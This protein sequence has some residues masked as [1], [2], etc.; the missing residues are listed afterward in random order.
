MK[1]RL[2]HSIN[3]L[4]QFNCLFFY[5]AILYVLLKVGILRLIPGP[6]SSLWNR[7]NLAAHNFSK[8]NLVEAVT[9]F[10]VLILSFYQKLCKIQLFNW[11]ILIC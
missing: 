6:K 3:F 1:F 8:V 10:I 4:V 9:Q 7:S 2:H 5:I 11:I